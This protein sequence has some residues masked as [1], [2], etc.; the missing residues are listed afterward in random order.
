VRHS[1]DF[2]GLYGTTQVT[3][4]N[5]VESLISQ[6]LRYLLSLFPTLLIETALRLSLHNLASIVDGFTMTYE[7]NRC[8]H[9]YFIAI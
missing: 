8:F 7:I 5:G 1:D 2:S 9:H 3:G 4:N 6:T